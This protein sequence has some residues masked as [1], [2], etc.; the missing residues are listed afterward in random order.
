MPDF[1]A[2]MAESSRRRADEVKARSSK[3]GLMSQAASARPVIPL[4]LPEDGF[5]LIAE[6]KLASPAD[7]RLVDGN[8]SEASVVA[9]ATAYSAAGAAAV[10]ILTTP[11]VFEGSLAH[12]ERASRAVETPVLR[13][14]FLVDPTQ[15]IEARAAGASGVLLIA[16]LVK[17]EILAEMTDLAA[18]LDMFTLVEV[19]EESDLDRASAV[20]DRDVLIGV[21][22]RDLATLQVDPSRLAEMAPLLP[23]GI[24]AVAES[25]VK[26]THDAAEAARLGYRLALVGTRLVTSDDP[27]ASTRRLIAAGRTAIQAGTPR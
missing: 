21:N 26:T 17:G 18:S 2:Q 13:K 6:A 20:L 1:L 27:E 22:T 8:D 3:S 15:V 11:E 24:P 9:M 4:D 14:D 10:S 16:R 19:F 5:D 23:E 12:L 7:G 25:G